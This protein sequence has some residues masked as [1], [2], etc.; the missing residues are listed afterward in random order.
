LHSGV[1]SEIKADQSFLGSFDTRSVVCVQ[2]FWPRCD[3][4]PSKSLSQEK[5]RFWN[6]KPLDVTGLFPFRCAVLTPSTMGELTVCDRESHQA[7]PGKI[8]GL[9]FQ[10]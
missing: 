3:G 4:G 1:A 9:N 6:L 10:S 5:Q 7:K 8:P 2:C